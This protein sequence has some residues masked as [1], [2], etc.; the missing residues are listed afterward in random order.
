VTALVV[1]P[2]SKVMDQV[3]YYI[4]NESKVYCPCRAIFRITRDD[5]P[6][7]RFNERGRVTLTCPSCGREGSYILTKRKLGQWWHH[8]LYVIHV[9]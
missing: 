8:I 2:K 7:L 3:Y 1:D 9:A 5:L 6:H 4:D